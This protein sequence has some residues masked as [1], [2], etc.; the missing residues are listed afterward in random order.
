MVICI[1]VTT[2]FQ[3]FNHFLKNTHKVVLYIC[4]IICLFTYCLAAIV[5]VFSFTL[6]EVFSCNPAGSSRQGFFII[7]I[8]AILSQA[9][10]NV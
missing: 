2:L 5:L 9:L 4:V 1:N 6:T 8:N 7:A 10:F 3:L